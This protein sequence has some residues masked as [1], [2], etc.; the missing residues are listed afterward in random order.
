MLQA[1]KTY[2]LGGKLSE[3]LYS[4]AAMH[5]VDMSS[6][7]VKPRARVKPMLAVCGN[8]MFLYG[9]TVEVR[10]QSSARQPSW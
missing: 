1:I 9:G 2:Q 7:S 4:P 5:G 3:L 10:T 6:N 8:S